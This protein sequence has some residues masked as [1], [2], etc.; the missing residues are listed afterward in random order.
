MPVPIPPLPDSVDSR[1]REMSLRISKASM[2]GGQ[3]FGTTLVGGN[4]DDEPTK[5]LRDALR[6]TSTEQLLYG[7][8]GSQFMPVPK[9]TVRIVVGEKTGPMAPASVPPR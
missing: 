4:P 2:A 7:S 9:G 1:L 8:S 5:A 3:P 6:K